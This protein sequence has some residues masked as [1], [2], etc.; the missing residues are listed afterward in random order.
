MLPWSG[1]DRLE[2]LLQTAQ[3][4]RLRDACKVLRRRKQAA[5]PASL[6]SPSGAGDYKPAELEGP[7]K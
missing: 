5:C 7:G 1:A 3:V 6:S 4:L 2:R